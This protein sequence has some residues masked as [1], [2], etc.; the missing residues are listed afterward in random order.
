MPALN[1]PRI[2]ATTST[3]E[4]TQYASHYHTALIYGPRF[5]DDF[6]ISENG[7]VA[8]ITAIAVRARWTTG[9]ARRPGRDAAGAP[10]QEV[11]LKG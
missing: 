2:A 10:A 6:A 8:Q 4:L 9:W 3:I 1:N 7:F 5:Q 11:A